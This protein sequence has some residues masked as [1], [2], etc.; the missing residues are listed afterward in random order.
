MY[1]DEFSLCEMNLLC[2]E[3]SDGMNCRKRH[4]KLQLHAIAYKCREEE[5]KEEKE[6]EEK[7]EEEK[8][9]KEKEEKEKEK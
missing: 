5:E 6:E 1:R 3:L 4:E 9:E 8:E 2:N 7:E